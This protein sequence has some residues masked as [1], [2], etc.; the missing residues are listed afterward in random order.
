M[1]KT[2]SPTK[3]GQQGF[4][5]IELSIVLVIIGLIVGGVLVGQDLIKAAQIRAMV[6]QIEKYDAAVNTFRSKYNGMP[7]DLQNGTSFFAAA[8]V[9]TGGNAAMIAGDGVLTDFAGT[10]VQV[11]GE[12]AAF[13]HQ[14]AL[15]NLISEPMTSTASISSSTPAAMPVATTLPAAKIGNG[16]LLMAYTGGATL[17]YPGMAGVNVFRI[18]GVTFAA[19]VS[20][21][22]ITSNLTPLEAFQIDTKKDDGVPNTG[23]VQATNNTANFNLNTDVSTAG[24][25]NCL[26]AAAVYNTGTSNGVQN[27]RLCQA[28]VRASF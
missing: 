5:L 25:A 6:S 4:T 26:S 13:W 3:Q 28:L 7:G 18:A 12:V 16:N 14:L 11:S 9:P 20:T 10:R 19:N 21:P 24:A 27:N 1:Q 8:S 2:P 15:S 22:T 23:T 17:T